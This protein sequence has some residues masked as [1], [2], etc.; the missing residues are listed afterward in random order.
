MTPGRDPE[1]DA[2][3]ENDIFEEAR[4]RLRIC[5]DAE[6]N[7]RS[8][9]KN[10]L[11]F[12]DGDQWDQKPMT[13]SESLDE[14]ELVI[15]LTDCFVRRVVNNMKQQR[16]RGKCHPIGDGAD[17]DKAEVINGLG[18]HI[19]YRSEAS[20]AYDLAGDSAVTIGWGY[21][22]LLTEY[23]APYSFDQ[24]MRIAPIRNTFT[25]YMDPGA[26]MPTA[27]DA[28]WCLISSKMKR[29]E[30]RRRYG[31]KMASGWGDGG[32]GDDN[33]DWSNEEEMRLAE[34]FRLREMSEMLYELTEQGGRKFNCLQRDL[35]SPES[36]ASRGLQ[37]TNQRESTRSRLEWF[38]LNGTNVVDRRVLPGE[39]IP[40][41]RVEGNVI[42]VDGDV[43]RRGMVRSMQDPQRMV[44]YGEC[45]KIKRLGLAPKA[46]W[47]AAE[48][49]LDGH[50]EWDSANRVA[51]S[52]LTYKP[53]TIVT[54]QGEIPLPPPQRQPPAQVEAGFVEFTESMRNNLLAIA[55]MP[56]EPGQ[57]PKGQVVSGRAI[58]RRQ[59]LSDQSHYQY[60]DNQTL[61]IA[62]CWRVMLSWIPVYY[63]EERMQRIIGEDSVPQMVK[64]NEA[65]E[66]DGVKSIKNDLSVGRYDV[67]MDTGP[68]YETRREE[69]AESMMDLVNSSALGAEIAK[70]GPDL[71]IR[72]LDHPYM[73]ELADRFQAMTPDGLKKVMEG[74]PSRAKAIVQSLASK[75]QQLEQALQQAQMEVK[76]GIAK[77]H[78]AATTKAHDTETRAQV[79]MHKAA[80][81]AHTDLAVEEIKAG[82]SLLNTHAEARHHERAAERIIEAGERV[83]SNSKSNG[84]A[85]RISE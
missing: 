79:D 44:N 22:R 62:Q 72:S 73:Q 83:E 1:I 35:P 39:Y 33:R 7:N 9:A 46:P 28:K 37:I 2:I 85:P 81:E 23:V 61:A 71:V 45:A 38:Q 18:R 8:K 3:S 31:D 24:D 36:L 84:A 74:L 43:R 80:L 70:V 75:N 77:A 63:S 11:Q 12:R 41:F 34:Y 29:T 21:F 32:V 14:P 40:V 25:V 16:P 42:D 64:I 13:T 58:Q 55:G 60:Y 57:D 52:V 10:D 5:I 50:P 56:N 76:Y 59:G 27:S 67:V 78:L 53:V 19:E 15:N 68:G 49:Q 47:V 48:G 26:I 82:A 51:Y 66:E 54:G 4:D 20:V 65:M 30:Y 6:S 17:I 69:G